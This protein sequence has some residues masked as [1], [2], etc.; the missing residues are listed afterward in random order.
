ML[1]TGHVKY[2]WLFLYLRTVCIL[3]I[4]QGK[5]ILKF[6]NLKQNQGALEEEGA[7]LAPA[8][9]TVLMEFHV[10]PSPTPVG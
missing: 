1:L 9:P 2:C 6:Q 10:H 8:Y 7:F 4:L 3:Q 5:K